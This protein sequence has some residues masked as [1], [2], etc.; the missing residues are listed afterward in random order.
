MYYG[1]LVKELLELELYLSLEPLSTCTFY[2]FVYLFPTYSLLFPDSFPK[3][4][5]ID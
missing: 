2:D 1:T 4:A 3:T 5:I